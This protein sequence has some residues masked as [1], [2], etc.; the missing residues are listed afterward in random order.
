MIRGEQRKR[1][2]LLMSVAVVAVLLCRQAAPGL[3]GDIPGPKSVTLKVITYNVCGLPDQIT[4]ERNLDPARTRFPR[5]GEK[6]RDYDVIGLQETFVPERIHIERKLRSYF[7][8]RGTDSWNKGTPG[9]GIYIFSRGRIPK[10]MFEMWEGLEGVDAWSHKGFVGATTELKKGFA[11][12]VYSLHGQAGGRYS[13]LRRHNYEQLLNGMKR[14]SA[15]SGRPVLAIGDFNCELNEPE[16]KWLLAN[17][18]LKHADPSYKGIDHI[19]YDENGSDWN[20]S[21]LRAGESFI[22]PDER[23]RLLSDHPAFEAVL[24]FEKKTAE[25]QK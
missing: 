3:G 23:G 11:I 21:V 15:G 14:F 5:I 1:I 19:F 9:S 8:A 17:S 6:L 16:C 24:K 13:E 22:T 2:Y 20:I 25:P 7:V 4:K 10:S 18:N 12:D